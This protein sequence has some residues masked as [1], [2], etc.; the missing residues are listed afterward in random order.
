MKKYVLFFN[1][2]PNPHLWV[3]KM[4][5]RYCPYWKFNC[6]C[7]WSCCQARDEKKTATKKAE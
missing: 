3:Y 4:D 2:H 6:Y 1:R 5:P 7:V